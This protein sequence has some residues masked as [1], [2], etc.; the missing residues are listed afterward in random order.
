MNILEKYRPTCLDDVV[1]QDRPVRILKSIVARPRPCCVLM[2]GETGTGKT[3]A[4]IAFAHELGCFT[5]EWWNTYHMIDGAD[6]SKELLRKWFRSGDSPLTLRAPG[7]W[8]VVCFEELEMVRSDAQ[9]QIKSYLDPDNLPR[10]TIVL[11]TSNDASGL[12]TACRDRF[13]T[14]HFSGGP[15]F[16]MAALDRVS[17]IWGQERPDQRLPIG[18]GSFGW[19]GDQFSMRRCLNELEM[20]LE[21]SA[22][23]ADVELEEVAA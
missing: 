9:I 22:P 1:G 20:E 17:W 23:L 8:H 19:N 10:N 7:G 6:I 3:S 16:G 21:L 5:D 18:W 12:K 11:A 15:E 14:L 2:E 13:T 4:A